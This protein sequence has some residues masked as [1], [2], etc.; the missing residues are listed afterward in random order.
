MRK[1]VLWLS[2]ETLGP[3]FPEVA[4]GPLGLNSLISDFPSY[5]PLFILPLA[6]AVRNSSSYKPGIAERHLELSS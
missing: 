3:K 1:T 6:T 4:S 2:W 5:Q